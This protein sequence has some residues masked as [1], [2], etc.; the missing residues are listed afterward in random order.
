[1][2]PQQVTSDQNVVKPV[3]R[4]DF[5]RPVGNL[6]SGTK[7]VR[8]V[9]VVLGLVAAGSGGA[10]LLASGRGQDAKHAERKRGA[11]G[12]E[13]HFG[14][15]TVQVITP[16]RGGMQR[17]TNQP[18]TVRAFEYAQLFAKVSGFVKTLNVDRGSRVKK[19]EL[20][21]EIYD[22][23]R[24]VAVEQA[25]AALE[26]AT[27]AV[28][29]AESSISSAQASV[30]AAKAEQN[31][32][33]AVLEQRKSERDYRKKQ[34]IRINELVRNGDVEERLAD[35][36]H[37]NY[38][39]AEG[40]VHSADAGIE[41]A[42]AKL[43]EA[44]AKVE[45]ARADL[46]AAHAGVKVSKANLDLAKVFVQYTKILSP[47]DGVVIFRGESVHPGTFIRSAAE[48][49]SAPLLT[50]AR[51]DKMR[52]IVLVP[53]RDVPYCKVGDP[54]TVQLDAL[55]GRVFKSKVSRIAESE[56]LN[57]RTM[58][59]EI[60]IDNADHALRDGMFGR[61]EIVLEKLIKSLTI[62][63][64][65]LVQRDGKGVGAVLVVR[66]GEL[67]RVPIRVGLDNGL[68][69]EVTSGLNENDQI[70]L[71]PD[72]SIVDGTKVRAEPVKPRAT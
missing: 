14:E 20:L 47:Y 61:A 54:A 28:A 10:Y 60:D 72:A 24:D 30:L 53:D 25:E 51:D 64:S 37:D 21:A 8:I 39:S 33:K 5:G 3:S 26:H 70:V 29:Q 68:R 2:S 15:P 19:G 34:Y 63:S 49:T 4:T 50:V 59:V 65:C 18:G 27:A 9:L 40:A 71:Q 62:P 16:E 41:T 66:D 17:T 38:L 58:R 35:E 13:S 36:E 1:M 7:W 23:E 45:Q 44:N 57:D 32:A 11:G 56:D 22:P 67:K 6:K 55:E 46:K 48:G 12:E 43:A 42:A 69:V 52:T 31:E